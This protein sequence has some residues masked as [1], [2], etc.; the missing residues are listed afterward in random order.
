MHGAPNRK[1]VPL[2][3]CRFTAIRDSSRYSLAGD[4]DASVRRR[5]RFRNTP[6]HDTCVRIQ[7]IRRIRNSD[8]GVPLPVDWMRVE[9]TLLR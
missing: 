9:E 4:C 2:G 7:R 6:V 5:I 3:S 8:D 1:V